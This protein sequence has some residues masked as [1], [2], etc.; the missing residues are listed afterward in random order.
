MNKL[1][2]LLCTVL[3]SGMI[4]AGVQ[5]TYMLGNK[6]SSGLSKLMGNG[7]MKFDETTWILLVCG[8]VVLIA[9]VYLS[10]KRK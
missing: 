6:V 9:G 3:G 8:A 1:L 4:G 2:G 5:R 7:G 10:L